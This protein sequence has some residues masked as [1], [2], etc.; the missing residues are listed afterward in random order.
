MRADVVVVLWLIGIQ[1]GKIAKTKNHFGGSQLIL[2]D[3]L[4]GA[5][6]WEANLDCDQDL[7]KQLSVEMSLG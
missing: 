5:L 7:S 1:T 3:E 6:N 4:R 2:P